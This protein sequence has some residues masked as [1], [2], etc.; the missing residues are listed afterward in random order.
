MRAAPC[1]S[2]AKFGIYSENAKGVEGYFRG[3]M[4]YSLSANT[5]GDAS[6]RRHQIVP[7][8]Q[9]R[10]EFIGSGG[11]PSRFGLS[12]EARCRSGA[13]GVS[14]YLTTPWVS[15]P[16]RRAEARRFAPTSYELTS[17]PLAMST[18]L[19]PHSSNIVFLQGKSK[20]GVPRDEERLL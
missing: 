10:S 16:P 20:A 11:E 17:C 14:I 2:A 1:F 4:L 6:S 12:H 9:K 13:K 8:F 15:S 3:G 18:Q 5:G 19:C 7:S